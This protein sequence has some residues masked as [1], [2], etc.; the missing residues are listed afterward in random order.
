MYKSLI[1]TP[2]RGR[3]RERKRER[4]RERERER[5]REGGRERESKREVQLSD[6]RIHTDE[7]NHV[8]HQQRLTIVQHQ[9]RPTILAQ[10]VSTF[11][12]LKAWQQ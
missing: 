5:G 6:T 7:G 10:L 9:Q 2:E 11:Q 8:Q 4:E 12:P 3:E 1:L